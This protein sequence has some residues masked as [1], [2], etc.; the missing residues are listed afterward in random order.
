MVQTS[1]EISLQLDIVQVPS[2]L[3]KFYIFS[4]FIAV[5]FNISEI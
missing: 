5:D 2:S 3:D 4:S 1:A